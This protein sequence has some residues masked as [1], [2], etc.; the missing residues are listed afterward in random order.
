MVQPV[1]DE[2]ALMV[3]NQVFSGFGSGL[4]ADGGLLLHSAGELAL[5][6]AFRAKSALRIQMDAD[7][8]LPIVARRVLRG[9]GKQCTVHIGL[10][11]FKI[12]A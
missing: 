1:D 12:D 3:G 10:N 11:D 5:Q 9:G 2:S 8:D 6:H 7:R 4:E